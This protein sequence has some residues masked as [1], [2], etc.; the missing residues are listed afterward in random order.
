VRGRWEEVHEIATCL[1]GYMRF[2]KQPNPEIDEQEE[3][4]AIYGSIDDAER[5]IRLEEKIKA[6]ERD[7][8]EE[9]LKCRKK[10]TNS[11]HTR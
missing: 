11:H 10:T 1:M 2:I 4:V 5:Y 7:T 3:L 6:T 8:F 9:R